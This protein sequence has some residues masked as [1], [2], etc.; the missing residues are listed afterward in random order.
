MLKLCLLETL[1]SLTTQSSL[2]ISSDKIKHVVQLPF[3]EV[4]YS[5]IVTLYEVTLQKLMSIYILK[6]VNRLDLD[7]ASKLMMRT[8]FSLFH[9]VYTNGIPSNITF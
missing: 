1:F 4:F 7:L 6:A 5:G 9:S 2:Y 3:S 8:W